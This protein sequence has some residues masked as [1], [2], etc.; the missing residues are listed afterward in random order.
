MQKT[1]EMKLTQA[2][3][4]QLRRSRRVC[5]HCGGVFV[6]EEDHKVCEPCVKEAMEMESF[7]YK[8]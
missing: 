3:I 7:T 5:Q 6:P 8:P 1:M 4:A 2:D